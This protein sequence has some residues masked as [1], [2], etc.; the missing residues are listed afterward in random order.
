MDSSSDFLFN[1]LQKWL[2]QSSQH[3]GNI[4]RTPISSLVPCLLP[5]LLFSLLSNTDTAAAIGIKIG[6][7]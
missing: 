2:V 1:L 3:F 6:H 4:L 7:A 5:S